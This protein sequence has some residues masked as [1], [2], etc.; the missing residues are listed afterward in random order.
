MLIIYYIDDINTIPKVALLM[1][2]SGIQTCCCE[3]KLTI[4]TRL[5]KGFYMSFN[6]A[7]INQILT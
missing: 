2:I 3:K 1:M 6:K 7:D 5:E 4:D